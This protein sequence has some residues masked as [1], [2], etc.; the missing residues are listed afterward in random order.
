VNGHARLA[1]A[2]SGPLV[3]A[4]IALVGCGGGDAP[5]SGSSGPTPAEGAARPALGG[6]ARARIAGRISSPAAVELSGLALA[7]SQRG[8]LW[9][10][11]DSGDSARVLAVS[12][13]GRRLAEL[14]VPGAENYDWE[15]IS[16]GPAPGGGHA[17]YVGDI[18]DN[19]AERPSVVVY[20][21]PEPRIAGGRS[22][23]TAPARALTLRYPDGAHD[24]EAL[25][26]SRSTGAL[27]IVTKS[28]SGVAGVYLAARP[29]EGRTTALRRV[30]RLSLGG[31]EAVT[32]GSVSG[33]GRTIALRSYFRAFVWSRRRGESVPTALRRKPCRV[34]ADLLAE[35][36]GETLALTREGGVLFTVPEGE[37]PAIRRYSPSG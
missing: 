31:G 23:A 7:R 27:V 12:T 3:G 25:L 16:V 28:F 6:A 32:A 37:R 18:G 35:G 30:G 2:L 9:A 36:Q 33:D 34:D 24:A 26:V 4:G 20:R 1:F 22:G 21:V 17:L 14:A 13:S 29:R 19:E 10:H 11:N 15:D 5:D 8:V